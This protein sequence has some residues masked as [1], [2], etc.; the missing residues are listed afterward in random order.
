[1]YQ[2]VEGSWVNYL[3]AASVVAL[4]PLILIFFLAQRYFV[5]GLLLSGSKG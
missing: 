3:M 5:R 2:S 4:S 1:M